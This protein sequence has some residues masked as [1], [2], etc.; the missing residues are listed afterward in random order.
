MNIFGKEGI[1][2]FNS[3]FNGL[4]TILLVI[5]IVGILGLIGYFGWSV[6]NKYYIDASAKNVVNAFE[7][8]AQNNKKNEVQNESQERN[9]IGDV[10]G[11]NSIYQNQTQGRNN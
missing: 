4:L 10:A 7:Q 6:Y 3:K 11:G 5:A 1:Y 8:V 9:E 2:M